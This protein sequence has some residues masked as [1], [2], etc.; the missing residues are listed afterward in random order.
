MIV[1][2]L[3]IRDN[4]THK[5]CPKCGETKPLTFEFWFRVN[6]PRRFQTPC[7]LCTA[8]INASWYLKTSTRK[9]RTKMSE[10]DRRLRQGESQRKRRINH[11]GKV[12]LLERKCSLKRLYGISIDQYNQM[13]AAQG[14]CCA[15]C[16]ETT[17]R[18]SKFW[19]VD[20][21]HGTKRVRGILCA[22]C[23]TM[24]GHARDNASILQGA[25]DYLGRTT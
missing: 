18:H 25:I 10:E 11:I 20:H 5:V 15:I 21:C 2:A 13:F 24:L 14:G 4:G 9:K 22:R 6:E 7:K 1:K 17:E 23:N 19:H 12:R 3:E 16:K 8:V